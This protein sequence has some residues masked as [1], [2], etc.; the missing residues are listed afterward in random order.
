M[1][2]L[3]GGAGAPDYLPCRYGTS[4]AVFRGPE[5]DLSR[6]YVAMLGGS[7]TFG[8]YVATP[9]PELVEQAL[10]RPVANLGGLNAGPDFYL[11]D[12]STLAVA[13][14]ARVAVVQIT[15]AEAMT[16]PLYTVHSR[17]NDRFLMATDALR[18]L[19]PEVDFADI[20]FTRHLLLVLQRTDADRF[21]TVLQVLKANW[22]DRM[23]A[24]LARLPK[25][26]LLL[27]LADTAVPDQ[28][29]TLDPTFGPLLIDRQM[30]AMLQSEGTGVIQAVPPHKARSSGA[31]GLLFPQTEALQARC[32]PGFAVH[33]EAARLLQPV[34]AAFF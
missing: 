31:A 4:R 11:S 20:H 18:D 1:M 33:V 34:L 14:G 23:R 12:P 25:H 9:Y 10:D 7:P 30:L 5:R 19:Y 29:D 28:A 15:G 24:L 32:E 27:W 2:V 13:A 8:K 22:L 17:R 3:E 26:R 21:C 16:N 6:P